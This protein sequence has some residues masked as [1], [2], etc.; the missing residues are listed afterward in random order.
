MSTNRRGTWG[1]KGKGPTGRNLCYCGCGREVLPPARTTFEP[2]CYHRWREKHDPAT[3]RSLVYRRDHG[4]CAICGT[5][6]ELHRRTAQETAAFWKRLARHHAE[7]LLLADELPPLPWM[8]PGEP[9]ALASCYHWSEIWVREDI[10]K[11]FGKGVLDGRHTWEAD[12]ILPVV[13]GGGECDLSNLRTLC[14]PCHRAETAKLAKR[15][16][17]QRRL[18]K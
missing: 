4:V 14:L 6:T 12:H 11:A 1:P 9:H 5:D 3:Q 7:D 8:K 13:E 17:E 10:E 2:A 16:A 15:R 18:K